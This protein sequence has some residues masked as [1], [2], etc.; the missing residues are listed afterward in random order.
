M[1]SNSLKF[2]SFWCLKKTQFKIVKLTIAVELQLNNDN[3][4]KI[5]V[6]KLKFEWKE[7]QFSEKLRNILLANKFDQ[8]SKK[9]EGFLSF[10]EASVL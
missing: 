8:S 6:D 9:S 10:I 1:S 4:Q 2:I 7:E 3:K 5:Q